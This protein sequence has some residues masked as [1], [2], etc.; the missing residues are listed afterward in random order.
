M[1]S[2]S[3]TRMGPNGAGS[4]LD[5]R[6][7]DRIVQVN[8][9]HPAAV[10]ELQYRNRIVLADHVG[11]PLE[12]RNELVI[13]DGHHP[14]VALALPA[15]VRVSPLGGDDARPAAGLGLHIGHFLVGHVAVAVVEVRFRGGVLDPV[16]RLELA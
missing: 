9:S 10:H 4:L 8:P 6:G 5:H 2:W 7:P 15:R 3:A 1:K 11:D 16:L 13:P 14:H 12:A